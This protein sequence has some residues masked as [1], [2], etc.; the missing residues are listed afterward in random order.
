MMN[1][2]SDL[3]KSARI[4]R[5]F[6]ARKRDRLKRYWVLFC[7]ANDP[8]EPKRVIEPLKLEAIFVIR[9]GDCDRED[10]EALGQAGE[11]LKTAVPPCNCLFLFNN[12]LQV[13]PLTC[14]EHWFRFIHDQAIA[15][16]ET[17]PFESVIDCPSSILQT[18]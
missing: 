16:L 4:I 11:L 5:G 2:E 8:S 3:K 14:T 13:K 18:L 6:S 1:P 15:H 17:K 12:S 7:E 9:S 10:S